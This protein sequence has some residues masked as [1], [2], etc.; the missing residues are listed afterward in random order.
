MRTLNEVMEVV[1]KESAI[2]KFNNHMAGSM[3]PR[4]LDFW[5]ISKTLSAVYPEATYD[6]T[7]GTF[8]DLE[9]CYFETLIQEHFK[10]FENA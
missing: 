3:I 9:D 6:N 1:A 2:A 10:R 7:L 5:S 8:V 4:G